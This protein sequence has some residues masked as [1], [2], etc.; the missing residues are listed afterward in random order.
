M[1][2]IGGSVNRRDCSRVNVAMGGTSNPNKRSPF[3]AEY[4]HP[5]LLRLNVR[6]HIISVHVD[7]TPRERGRV[8]RIE[9]RSDLVR[10]WS[11]HVVR[12]L[13]RGERW[14]RNVALTS[15]CCE[16]FLVVSRASTG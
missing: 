4:L 9:Y 2:S 10:Q 8:L 16:P 14:N 15:I 7:A 6:N 12:D 1:I 3:R 11:Q 13:R 5:I